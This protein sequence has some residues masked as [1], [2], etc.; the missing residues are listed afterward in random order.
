MHRFFGHLGSILGTKLGPC[1]H[2][3]RLKWGDA[4]GCYPLLCFVASFILLFHGF[5]PV[6]APSWL[7]GGASGPHLGGL[8]APLLLFLVPSW[9]P[10]GALGR[11]NGPGCNE[12][13]LPGPAECAKRSAAQRGRRARFLSPGL[14]VLPD[15]SKA[16]FLTSISSFPLPNPLPEAAHSARPTPKREVRGTPSASW[17]KRMS[18]QG[19]FKT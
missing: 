12:I 18:L 8:L 6:F 4:V 14:L 3:F 11:K 10:L 17:P 2:N 7:D 1:W 5:D 9:R 13:F 19:T 16:K 15:P